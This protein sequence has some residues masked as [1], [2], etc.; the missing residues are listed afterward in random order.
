MPGTAGRFLLTLYGLL[1][2]S[3]D[4]KV[5]RGDRPGFVMFLATRYGELA[6]VRRPFG[7]SRGALASSPT[8]TPSLRGASASLGSLER[9]YRR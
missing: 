2:Q 7:L 8:S 5:S 3:F 1:D 6:P 9:P 4:R